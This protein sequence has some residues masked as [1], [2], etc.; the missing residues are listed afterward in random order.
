MNSRGALSD[1]APEG[2]RVVQNHQAGFRSAAH[3]VTRSQKWHNSTNNKT[4][5]TN[6]GAVKQWNKKQPIR[7]LLFKYIY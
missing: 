4:L 7:T 6:Y 5:Q 2:E 3:K 1:I